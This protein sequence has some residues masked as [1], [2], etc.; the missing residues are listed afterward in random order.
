MKKLALL[1]TMVVIG[2]GAVGC[3]EKSTSD[4]AKDAVESASDDAKD[5]AEDASK[6][7]DEVAK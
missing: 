4:K 5:A 2:F 6:K 3:Q 1:L 7:L